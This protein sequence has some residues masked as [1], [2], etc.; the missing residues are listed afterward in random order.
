[1]AA[2][3]PEDKRDL[4]TR[5][6]QAYAYLGFVRPDGFPQVNPIWFDWDGKHIILNTARGR[7]KDRVMHKRPAVA[8]AIQDPGDPERYLEVRGRVVEETEMD[9]YDMICRLSEK[10]SGKY[11]FPKR[12]GEVRVTYKI[13]PEQVSGSK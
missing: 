9:A 4:L 8:L 13:L 12:P 7:V 3:I 5:E 10:Y 6:K 11:S 2:V 1:M